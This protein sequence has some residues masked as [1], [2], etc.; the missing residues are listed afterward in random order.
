MRIAR[1]L[2]PTSPVPV[3]AL[4]RDGCLYDVAEL[5]RRFDTPFAPERFPGADDFHKRVVALGCAGLD[6]LDERLRGGDRPTE[7]R[8]WPGEFL[9]LAPC[10]TERVMYAQAEP[11][12]R[13]DEP[14]D[15]PPYRIGNARGL[16][17]HDA[18]IPFP[19]REEQPDLEIGVAAMLGEELRRASVDEVD[20]SIIGYS[21]LSE[22]TARQEERRHGPTRARDFA[23]Q[24]GPVLVTK[25]ELRATPSP[26]AR[27]RAG[28]GAWS[29]VPP[30]LPG[31]PSLSEAIAFISEHVALEAGDVVG[32][33]IGVA[34]A[35]GITIAYGA[36]VEVSVERLGKLVGRPVRGPEAPSFRRLTTR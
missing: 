34:S 11:V 29:E 18:V 6:E 22:W 36:T 17:G 9:W 15:G 13:T 23:P 1:V 5:E 8:I 21:I 20:R 26:R 30:A 16:V 3:L 32:L 14:G 24:L 25:D 28:S 2:L 19:F 7:A 12:V 4:E 10:A 27:L 31:A 35:Q 33:R